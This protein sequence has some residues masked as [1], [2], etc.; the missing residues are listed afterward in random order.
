MNTHTSLMTGLG[1]GVGISYFLDVGRGARR[2]AH[3]RDTVAHSAAVTRRAIGRTR[4]DALHRTAGTFAA[5]RHVVR[6]RDH[7]DDHVLVERVRAKLGR[8]VS[9]PHA[10]RVDAVDGMVTLSGAILEREADALLA[11]VGRVRGVRGVTD[12]LEI[13][14]HARHVPAL[15]GGRAPAG[16]HLDVLQQH[17]APTTRLIVGAAGGMLVA[18][19]AMRR[20]VRG[21]LAAVIGLGLVARAAANVPAN[22]LTGVGS[23]RRAV[24]VQKTITINAPASDV[25]AFWS[26]FEN[27]PQFTSRILEVRQSRDPNRS[28]W[29][30]WGPAGLPV[31]FDAEITRTVPNTLIAWRTVEGSPVAHAGVVRFDPISYDATRVHIRMSYN[32]PAGWLGHGVAKAF[33]VDPKHSMDE[34]LVRMKTLIETGRPPHDAAD[35]RLLT[36]PG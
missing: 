27:F 18:A 8:H 14:E 33:G 35:R 34:D 3:L 26:M 21:S 6:R 25:F 31:E 19:G 30:V 13:H 2:R 32:P 24:D 22:R 1:L 4:R 20:D 11:A 16:D 28:H 10:V 9:H 12:R 36:Q 15:Q 7:V 17:W 5:A 23:R 29:R